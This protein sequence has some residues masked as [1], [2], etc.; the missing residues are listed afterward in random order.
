[1]SGFPKTCALFILAFL[2]L[3]SAAETMNT[4]EFQELIREIHQL[5]RVDPRLAEKMAGPAKAFAAENDNLAD[6]IWLAA[7]MAPCNAITRG[8]QPTR[9]RMLKMVVAASQSLEA[10][11]LV[12][13]LRMHIADLAIR[14]G[15]FEFAFRQLL[16]GLRW[17]E[18]GTPP[19][20]RLKSMELAALL[21][22]DAGYPFDALLLISQVEQMGGWRDSRARRGFQL[23]KCEAYGETGD[24][25]RMGAVLDE[26]ALEFTPDTDPGV[27][28]SYW[29]QKTWHALYLLS[30]NRAREFLET[31]RER[32]RHQA[33]GIQKAEVLLLDAILLDL[34]KASPEMV[35]E[36]LQEARDEYR[37]VG[38][39]VRHAELIHRFLQMPNADPAGNSRVP[40]LRSLQDVAYGG[41]N[42]LADVR[43]LAAWIELEGSVEG[44][45]PDRV[46]E[47]F[48]Q[49]SR[50]LEQFRR[51]FGALQVEWAL[52][53]TVLLP[54]SPVQ[55]HH[56][57]LGE[58]YLL[59]LLLVCVVI[60]LYLLMRMRMQRHLNLKLA[61]SF[62][63]AREAELRA[64]QSNQLKTQFLANVSHEIKTPMSGLVGMASL[65]DE[66][67]T[68]PKQ[69]QYLSTI[70]TCSQNLLVLMNDLLDLGR[71][72]SGRLEIEQVPF[73]VRKMV[74]YCLRI[75]EESAVIKGLELDG[76]VRP[77]V[78]GTIVGD[79]TR[80]GQIMTNLLH[81]AVKFTGHG[82]VL[83]NVDYEHLSEESGTL[84]IHVRDTGIGIPPENLQTVFE[85]FS[86]IEN[87]PER[88]ST[89]SGLGLA[90]C[91]RLVELMGGTIGVES[92]LNKGTTFT[93][94]LPA[95]SE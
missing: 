79:S 2:S 35:T 31:A 85:P 21:N 26:M 61:E 80:I 72:E 3:T 6:R 82:S 10:A 25:N 90:I 19:F 27:I 56:P 1:M 33:A 81:N 49:L 22:L 12:P 43:A 9:R 63:K 28:D 74:D 34:E 70:R 66:L 29:I 64:E 52:K 89:G 53:S 47:Q 32:G 75:V 67:V 60:F 91:K 5:N 57:I 65:L 24:Y 88:K 36:R 54:Y 41:E 13:F 39:P 68:D 87:H 50:N 76:Q 4:R 46:V 78:P 42:R 38:L 55:D 45:M 94:S 30:K 20:I 84:I 23:L 48:R 92:E 44:S 8:Y 40:F 7:A 11:Y 77:V 95:K 14:H 15:D 17:I 93:V 18:P 16:D 71:I 73:N 58:D 62:Q 69:R 59:V 86:R 83:L 37:A 51:D